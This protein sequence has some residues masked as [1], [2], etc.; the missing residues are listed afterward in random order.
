MGFRARPSRIKQF[1]REFIMLESAC[2]TAESYAA[3]TKPQASG[4][5]AFVRLLNS[6]T[7]VRP[8]V[9]EFFRHLGKLSD[10]SAD[11]LIATARHYEMTDA[12]QAAK[13]D[14]HYQQVASTPLPKTG[15]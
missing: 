3:H 11:E 2:Q 4:G 14:Q 15:G 8:S 10:M 7:E 5:S 9:E 6:T 13:A 1:A 12:E